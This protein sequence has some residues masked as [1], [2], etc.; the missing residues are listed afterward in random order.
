MKKFKQCISMILIVSLIVTILPY[1]AHA[2]ETANT[3]AD[4]NSNTDTYK[5]NNEIPAI[6]GEITE[7]RESNVKHFMKDDHSYE[8]VIYEEPVHYF[9]DGQWKDVDN[10]LTDGM[11]PSVIADNG[12]S[13]PGSGPNI[14]K[15]KANDYEVRF[16]KSAGVNKLVQLHKGNYELSWSIEEAG[17]INPDVSV[18]DKES[19]RTE[20]TDDIEDFVR[21][22]EQYAS[23]SGTEKQRASEILVNN[24]MKKIAEKSSSEVFYSGILPETDLR[25]RVSSG[26]LKED[27]ILNSYVKDFSISFF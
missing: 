15:N 12:K 6:T 14:I 18:P 10:S 11:D 2:E 5:K 13:V 4:L 23:F 7:K 27:I 24:E 25:Y 22:S 16:A 9:E 3:A 19:L 21:S 17:N 26:V 8:A 20:I 1:S